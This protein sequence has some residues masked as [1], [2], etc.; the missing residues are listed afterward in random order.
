[1]KKKII[2][3]LASIPVTAGLAMTDVSAGGCPYGVTGF[4]PGR[5]GRFID[6]DGNGNCDLIQTTTTTQ[7]TTS[8]SSTSDSASSTDSSSGDS[9]NSATQ[10]DANIDSSSAQDLGD[11]SANADVN[12]STI[13]DSGI[14]GD[15]TVDPTNY[16]AIPVS[17]LILAGYLFTHFLFS[18]GILNQKKHRR[19]WNLLV[20]IGYVGTGITGVFLIFLLNLGISSFLNNS[21]TW[22]HVELSILMVI[23][24]LIHIHLYKKP[25]KNM[26]KVLFGFKSNKEKSKNNSAFE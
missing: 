16:Y 24:T 8:D 11:V 12:N 22:L 5:C 23:G 17:I 13:N 26:F 7:S 18:R 21:I 25:F 9:S 10:S 15:N 4:C 2:K 3:A 19:I 6:S 1:M 14:F 20:T